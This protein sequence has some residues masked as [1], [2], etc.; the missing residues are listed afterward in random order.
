MRALVED[1][2]YDEG[3]EIPPGAGLYA[4]D[5]VFIRVVALRLVYEPDLV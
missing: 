5:D 3:S 4:F 1:Q 2:S